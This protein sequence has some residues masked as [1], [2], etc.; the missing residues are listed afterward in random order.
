MPWILA[1][2]VVVRQISG[3]T[4]TRRRAG[5]R[6]LVDAAAESRGPARLIGGGARH[7]RMSAGGLETA[8]AH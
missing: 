8:A 3:E 2:A 6:A 5:V 4:G 1:L 7:R